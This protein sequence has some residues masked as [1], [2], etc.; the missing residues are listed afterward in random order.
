MYDKLIDIVK[1]YVD[2]LGVENFDVF[3]FSYN[4]SNVFLGERK[5]KVDSK[6]HRKYD[7]NKI[8]ILVEDFLIALNPK[9]LDYYIV[10]KED[11]SFD[12]SYESGSGYSFLDDA[13]KRRILVGSTGTIKDAFIVVHE[14]FH[15][16]NMSENIVDS[17]GRIFFTECL[18]ILGEFLLSDYLEN[19]KIYEHRC[20]MQE[21]FYYL[22]GKAVEV[23]FNLELI[24]K[25]LENGFLNSSIIDSIIYSYPRDCRMDVIETMLKMVESE[26]VTLEEEQSYVASGLVATYMYDRIKSN[27]KYLNELFDLNQVLDD[28]SLEQVLDYLDID[29]GDSDIADKSYSMLRDKYKKYIKRW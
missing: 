21:T 18:S 13:G 19:R 6:K 16:I 15:D 8:D 1:K 9:Y 28:Y 26:W 11:G 14:L 3:Q 4:C 7:L 10:R 20:F 23:N 22:R 2:I 24:K 29:Y 5:F 27:K 25:Y 17:E 12:F